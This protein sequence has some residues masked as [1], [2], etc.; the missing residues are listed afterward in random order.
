M[1][2]DQREQLINITT[3]MKRDVTRVHCIST[4]IEAM[5][6]TACEVDNAIVSFVR[7]ANTVKIGFVLSDVTVTNA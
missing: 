4:L 2:V 3:R 7:T 5:T 1:R 6:I